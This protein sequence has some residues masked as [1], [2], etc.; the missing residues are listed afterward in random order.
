MIH[1]GLS[2]VGH[3]CM[4]ALHSI[5]HVNVGS[6]VIF[7]TFISYTYNWHAP[8]SFVSLVF[9]EMSKKKNIYLH[10]LI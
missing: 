3:I 5:K 8:I 2:F 1:S 10:T 9:S 6:L 4:S 7:L